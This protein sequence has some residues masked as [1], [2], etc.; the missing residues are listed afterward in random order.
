MPNM[1]EAYRTLGFLRL[2]LCSFPIYEPCLHLID[3]RSVIG[4]NH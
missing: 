2:L 1:L 4:I 3:E